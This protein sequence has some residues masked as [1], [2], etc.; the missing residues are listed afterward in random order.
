MEKKRHILVVEDD[1]SILM[2]LKDNLIIEGYNVSTSLN[3]NEGLKMALQNQI[4][5]LIL[6]IMLPGMNGLEICKKVKLEKPLIPVLMLTARS[7]EMDKIIGLDYGADD[8]ITKPF[9]LSELLARIRAVLRRSYPLKTE[10]ERYAFGNVEINFKK[11]E[12]HIDGEEIRFT[13]KE[14]SILHYLIQHKGEVVHRHDLLNEV[15]GY[16]KIPTT[17]TVDNFI[18]DIRK[19]IEKEP[20]NPIF[21]KTISGVGYKFNSKKIL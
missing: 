21:I 5:L 20:S 3:G 10:L 19:K 15:W 6:D 9:S 13:R 4:D 1:I 11:M 8:Y 18:L 17:R 14:F 12:V 2:G 16:D 7:S